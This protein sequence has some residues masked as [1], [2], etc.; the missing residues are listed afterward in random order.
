M[1]VV[2][3]EREKVIEESF[4]RD[5]NARL[6]E[7]MRRKSQRADKLAS[8]RETSGLSDPDL[9]NELLDLQI[10]SQTLAALTLI[11]LVEVAWADG[12]V[13]QAEKE[14]ILQAAHSVGISEGS[15][16]H[17]ILGNWLSE[18]PGPELF[19]AW[20]DYVQALCETLT[21]EGCQTL[22]EDVIGR[23][24]RVAEA[25]GG[26]LGLIDNVSPLERKVMEKLEEAF[27]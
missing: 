16:S 18:P 9:L 22:R 11:P 21:A 7:A 24:H 13:S 12:T 5:H 20:K 10:E 1:S 14:S 27:R 3:K 17:E 15:E 23:V 2:L 19:K 4:F 26:F 8:L 25:T 6:L